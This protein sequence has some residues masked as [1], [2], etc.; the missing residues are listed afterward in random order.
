M[1][2]PLEFS[3]TSTQKYAMSPHGSIQ[4]KTIPKFDFSSHLNVPKFAPTPTTPSKSTPSQTFPFRRRFAVSHIL[5]GIFELANVNVDI[6]LARTNPKHSPREFS[7]FFRMFVLEQVP[8]PFLL[9][10]TPFHH[11]SKRF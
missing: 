11:S 1:K 10:P 4:P 6:L 7:F 8:E 2:A 3:A 9:L 5:S